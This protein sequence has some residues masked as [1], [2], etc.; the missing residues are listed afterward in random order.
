MPIYQDTLSDSEILPILS[1][2]KSRWPR[3]VIQIHN[4]QVRRNN[5]LFMTINTEPLVAVYRSAALFL[6]IELLALLG[7]PS[8]HASEGVL[9]D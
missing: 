2:I 7:M 1:F 5:E 6:I 3:Q 9:T 8:I 4:E